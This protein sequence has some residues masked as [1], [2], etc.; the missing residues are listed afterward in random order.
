[1]RNGELALGRN[2][3][4]H[5]Q[6]IPFE[7]LMPNTLGAVLIAEIGSLTTRVT[8]LDQADGE[9]RMLGRAELPSSIEPPYNNALLAVLECAAQISELTGRVLL[10]D[11]QLLM[12]QTNER[13]GVNHLVALSSAAG[14]MALVITAIASDVSARSALHAA[15]STYTSVLQVVTLDDAAHQTLV[16]EKLSWIER[17]VQSLLALQPDAVFIAGGLEDGAVDSLSRL[18]HIVGLT[19]LRTAVDSSGQQRQDLTARPVIYAGNS[20]ARERVLEALSDRAEMFVVDNVRPTLEQEQLEPARHELGRLYSKYI[21]PRLPGLP[22]LRRLSQSP[23]VT[24]CSAE[25][26][27]TRFLAERYARRVLTIDVGS[28]SSSAFLALPDPA[29]APQSYHVAVLGNCGT[30]YG[31]S[32]VMIERGLP[33]IL[34]WLPFSLNEADLTHWLLNKML[35]PQL[36]PVTREDLY[37]EQAVAR[38]ALA[39]VL[40][41][42][43]DECPRPYYDL[44]VLG[45]GVLAHVPHPAMAALV[46]LDALQPTGEP[47]DAQAAPLMALDLHLDTLGLLPACGAVAMLDVDA[48]VTMFD[49]DALRNVPLATCVVALGEGKPGELAVEAELV[50][51]GR[52]IQRVQVAHGQIVRL[53]LPPGTQGHITLRPAGGVSIGANAPGVEVSSDVGALNGSALGVVIDARGRP[54]RLP[55]N[56]R[57]RQARLWEWLVALGA[58]QTP[59]PYVDLPLTTPQV[60]VSAAAPDIRPLNGNSPAPA[61]PPPLPATPPPAPAAPLPAL[62]ETAVPDAPE[63]EAAQPGIRITFGDVPD[64]LPTPDAGKLKPGSRISLSD[65]VASEPAP[66]P[67]PPSAPNSIDS[68]MAKLRETVE[69]PKK[70]GWFGRKK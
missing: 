24:V 32:T 9:S 66:A 34:R 60:T 54:L 40:D 22:A 50:T 12:P 56:E 23:V 44:V 64:E 69:E 8:L 57:E 14:T 58:E 4:I 45:G 27:M 20:A 38:E 7:H 2:L 62:A 65:P 29:N 51:L 10:R 18:A 13:D 52:G 55:E 49:R 61:T 37:I 15:R 63:P 41:A 35:R 16:D 26:L 53:P 36:V 5:H 42:L 59:S 11:G 47:S 33:N 1:M 46:L 67:P 28:S 68:D 17:Q 70:R 39:L 25:G 30:G 48:A 19:A 21:L 3:S 43:R 6:Q 31:L